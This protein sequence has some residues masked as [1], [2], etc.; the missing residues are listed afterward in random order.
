[1]ERNLIPIIFSCN[2]RE[3]D[4][5]LAEELQ[6]DL[7]ELMRKLNEAYYQMAAHLEGRETPI[8]SPLQTYG[9]LRS[10]QENQDVSTE[11]EQTVPSADALAE[12]IPDLIE[13]SDSEEMPD[14]LYSSDSEEM[15]D[16]IDSSE[17]EGNN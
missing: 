9:I 14:L 10:L 4:D 8:Q 6:R 12:E 17:D 16:L 1:M 3:T 11:I 15:P 7:P 2:E 13:T 5:K